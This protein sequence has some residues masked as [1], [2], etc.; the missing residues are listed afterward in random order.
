MALEAQVEERPLAKK[1][2]ALLGSDG[3]GS[4]T[5]PGDPSPDYPKSAMK[6]AES[7]KVEKV[8]RK[9]LLKNDDAELQRV[10]YVCISPIVEC[11]INLIYYSYLG[12]SIV[13]SLPHMTT[14]RLKTEVRN[15]GP[16]LRGLKP[17]T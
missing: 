15:D 13:A 6:A 3:T 17:T 5:P 16:L 10:G 4:T 1:Q 7:P 11:S 12:K 2:E 9:A 14:E 8:P